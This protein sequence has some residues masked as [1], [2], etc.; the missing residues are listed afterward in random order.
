MAPPGSV[1]KKAVS[2]IRT[3]R[4]V[5]DGKVCRVKACRVTVSCMR[6]RAIHMT[7]LCRC[8]LYIEV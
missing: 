4:T 8:I 5:C 3:V 2:A 1:G 7:H 6:V